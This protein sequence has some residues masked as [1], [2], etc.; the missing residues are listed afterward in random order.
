V[1]SFDEDISYKYV[2]AGGIGLNSIL[3]FACEKLI[4]I[5]LTRLA[6]KKQARNKAAKFAAE[7]K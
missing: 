6:D 3:T 5:H 7:M 1:L 4:V 2:I